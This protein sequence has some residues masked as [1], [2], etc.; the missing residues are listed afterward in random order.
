MPRCKSCQKEI[1]KFDTDICPYCGEKNPIDPNYET[2]DV[3]SYIKP[4]EQNYELYRSKSRKT[5]AF[6]CLGLGYLGVHSFYLGFRR[7]GLIQCLVSILL[8]AGIGSALFF[9]KAWESPL[10]FLVPFFVIWAVYMLQSIYYFKKDNLKDAR[11][12]FLR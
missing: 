12:E 9:T 5:A 11:G 1:T 2:I 6:L 8:I 10:A 4:Q 3:T 7:T